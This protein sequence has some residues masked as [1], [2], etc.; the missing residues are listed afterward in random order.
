M[1]KNHAQTDGPAPGLIVLRAILGAEGPLRT[2]LYYCTEWAG[3]RKCGLG[4]QAS[5]WA[6]ERASACGGAWVKSAPECV[7]EWVV[8]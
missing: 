5:E 8:E 2:Q 3:T 1:G 4:A 6:S 7:R